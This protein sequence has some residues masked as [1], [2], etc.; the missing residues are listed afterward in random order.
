MKVKFYSIVNY[1]HLRRFLL[2]P[3]SSLSLSLSLSLSH[4]HTHTHTH[5]AF[6][7]SANVWN[8]ESFHYAVN[9]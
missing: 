2:P 7:F 9:G 6:K 4:T 1:I 8:V 3:H 5:V